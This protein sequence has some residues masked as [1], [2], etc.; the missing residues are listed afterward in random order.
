MELTPEQ[1]SKWSRYGME[2]YNWIMEGKLMASV[3]PMDID[4]IEHLKE[5]EGIKIVVNLAE[6]PWPGEWTSRSGIV[7]MHF[8]IVDMS[9]PKEK[10]VL[11]M[12]NVID[13]TDGPV[14]VHCAAGIGRTGTIIALYLVE[15]GMEP[16]EA[17]SQV[18]QKRNGSIQTK[19]QEQMV[20]DWGR[21]K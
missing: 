7:H 18:R 8:P 3:Y 6:S 9:I 21:R 5:N 12:I 1:I 13:R 2:P 15:K 19:A 17:I 20:H 14:M 11:R 4:Y 16:S 10:D